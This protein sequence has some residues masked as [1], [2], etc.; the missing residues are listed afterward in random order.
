MEWIATTDAPNSFECSANGPV[1][2]Y[3]FNKV[4]T[5]CRLEAAF[6]AEKRADHALIKSNP[7]NQQSGRQTANPRLFFRHH[8]DLFSFFGFVH[9]GA[10]FVDRFV[11]SLQQALQRGHDFS[12]VWFS[13]VSR[14]ND[15]IKSRRN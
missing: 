7:E 5:T 3:G 4:M 14:A 1:F 2:I 6:W 10:R 15:N 8:T 12:K 13:A 9:A 11:K